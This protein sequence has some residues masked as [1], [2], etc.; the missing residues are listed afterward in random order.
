MNWIKFIKKFPS[1]INIPQ[2]IS[3]SLPLCLYI[4]FIIIINW[5]TPN[6][7]N[8]IKFIVNICQP[9]LIAQLL[10]WMTHYT[11]SESSSL[12]SMLSLYWAKFEDIVISQWLSIYT[13]IY[14]YLKHVNICHLSTYFV[15]KSYNVFFTKSYNV[16]F[17][18]L[19]SLP[20][21]SRYT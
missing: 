12:W 8:R 20:F 1:L 15:T 16:F 14:V 9:A 19:G 2:I 13:F 18:F 17:F 10:R 11:G 3:Q 5:W 21:F 4:Y 6:K 7:I